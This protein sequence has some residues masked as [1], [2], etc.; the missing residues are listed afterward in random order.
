M[1]NEKKKINELVSDDDDPTAELEAITVRN[2]LAREKAGQDAEADQNT[3]DF[4]DDDDAYDGVS[5][6]EL[7]ADL[8]RRS[9]TIE[10]LQFD[11]EQLRS[12]WLGLE[13]EIKAREELTE[14]LSTE[15]KSVERNLTR[16]QK[17]LTERDRS[18]K[19]LKAEIRER[20][21]A[22]RELQQMAEEARSLC[23]ELQAGDEINA[24][25]R[26]LADQGGALAAA[27]DELEQAKAQQERTEEYADDLRRKLTDVA[28]TSDTAMHQTTSLKTALGE[29]ESRFQDLQDRHT[30]SEARAKA[31]EVALR[32]AIESHEQELKTLRF[33]LGEAQ[34][35]LTE[36]DEVSEQLA[37]DLVDTR[38]F[39]EQLE[40]MLTQNEEQSQERISELEKQKSTLEK[41]V[42][43][44]E[45]KL[46][47]KSDAINALI[48]ELA[49]KSGEIDSIGE[50]EDVIQEIDDRMSERF[51]DQVIEL[52]GERTHADR[53]TR[54]LVGRIDDQLLRF[55]LFKDR[56][57][58][59]RTQQNDI[60]LK[61]QYISRR[62]A[63]IETEGET[64]R[65]IDWG[66]KNGVYVNKKRITEHFLKSGD[67]VTIGTAEFKYE[68]RPK[69][70]V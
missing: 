16:K 43:E 5:M 4:D 44:L 69:R 15:L 34:E 62:H 35:T 70:D 10:K 56:L 6:S 53:T 26:Q 60:Q 63:V 29:A 50:M 28:S 18:I 23:E 20:D 38:N 46:E 17:L 25:R 31:A 66:S 67:I 68:E 61:A 49:K 11:V 59:G 52:E 47:T 40:R 27:H 1:A 37:S 21:L 58:I 36:R 64:T 54:L 9:D 51:D 41:T 12:R 57:T 8:K 7:K 45:D 39:K 65:V 30:T 42:A 22:Y 48:A 13:T 24:A 3:Y 33:E 2:F 14:N 32:K 55:P 19:A